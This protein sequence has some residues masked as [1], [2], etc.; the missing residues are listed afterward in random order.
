MFLDFECLRLFIVSMFN[1]LVF[2]VRETEILQKN[3]S[4]IS[5]AGGVDK[6][7][8]PQIEE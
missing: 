6:R 7:Y 1:Y 8:H 5:G 3:V 2:Y 4:S